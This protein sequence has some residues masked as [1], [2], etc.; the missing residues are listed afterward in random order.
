MGQRL[1]GNRVGETEPMETYPLIPILMSDMLERKWVVEGSWEREKSVGVGGRKEK[2]KKKER[3]SYIA[4]NR[5][6]P[7]RRDCGTSAPSQRHDGAVP[8]NSLSWSLFPPPVP[9]CFR[10]HWVANHEVVFFQDLHCM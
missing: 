3:R 6:F 8:C 2:K 4:L 7:V 10:H 1:A 5:V 9:N